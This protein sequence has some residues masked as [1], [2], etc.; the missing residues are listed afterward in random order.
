LY[1]KANA[2]NAGYRNPRFFATRSISSK[3]VA[4]SHGPCRL[5]ETQRGIFRGSSFR[6]MEITRLSEYRH[7]G[8]IGPR[9]DLNGKWDCTHWCAGGVPDT[10]VDV[11]Q[12]ML[13]T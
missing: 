8:H 13:A 5:L 2:L 1:L 9:E 11:L 12:A 6:M 4:A 10:W 7:D 3:P